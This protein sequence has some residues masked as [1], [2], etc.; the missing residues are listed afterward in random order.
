MLKTT[1]FS[2]NV[3]IINQNFVLIIRCFVVPTLLCFLCLIFYENRSSGRCVR[4][5]DSLTWNVNGRAVDD[6][7][8]T[9]IA[10]LRM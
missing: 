3:K 6:V 2:E 9:V 8:K 10:F 1:R 5:C 7:L 4:A